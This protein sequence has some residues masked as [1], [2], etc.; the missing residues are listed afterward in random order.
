MPALTLQSGSRPGL[1]TSMVWASVH[2]VAAHTS[3]TRRAH[4]GHAWFPASCI[5]ADV[6]ADPGDLV[7]I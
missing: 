6:I 7:P 3:H 1:N 5:L 2:G 4:V